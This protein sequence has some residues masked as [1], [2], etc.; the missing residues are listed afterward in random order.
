MQQFIRPVQIT[1]EAHLVQSFWKD[2]DAPVGVHFNTMVLASR[3]P[4]VFDTGIH[5]DEHG[6]HRAVSSVVDPADVR[7][8][9]ISHDDPD[10]TGNL[11]SA[12]ERFPN[13]TAV[14]SWWMAE[15]LTGSIE[16]DPR[17]MRWVVAGDTLD[18]GDRALVFQR[19]PLYD[20]P[21]T[22]MA[23]DPSTGLL[24]AGDLGGA[25]GPEPVLFVEEI[26]RAEHAT[27]FVDVH[28][29][30]S[31][32]AAVV[33]ERK[34]QATVDQLARLEITTWANTHGPVYEGARVDEAIDLLRRVPSAPPAEEP[35]QADLDAIVASM[36]TTV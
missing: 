25:L 32:W 22:R 24:W 17:R 14:V 11:V 28:A 13:A 20:S 26:D 5:A 31:P 36:L 23:F 33:D 7:W 21:T 18:I 29:L 35:S 34:Y 8:I 30:V 15:R 1:P 3:E 10:H 27:S 19:P 4:V 2:P 6:W 12:M 16:L 9:V